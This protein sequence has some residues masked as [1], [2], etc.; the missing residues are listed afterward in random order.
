M[1]HIKLYET[2]NS[3]N[4][5]TRLS[6]E[7]IYLMCENF[8]AGDDEYPIIELRDVD[9]NKYTE[10]KDFIKNN[11]TLQI[12]IDTKYL[13]YYN[14][15]NPY[16]KAAYIIL[17]DIKVI[18]L[19][20]LHSTRETIIKYDDIKSNAFYMSKMY[21]SSLLHELIHAYDDYR[22]NGKYSDTTNSNQVINNSYLDY[23]NS[24]HEVGARFNQAFQKTDLK[25]WYDVDDKGMIYELLP[26]D[27]CLKAFRRN[28]INYRFLPETEKKRMSSMFAKYYIKYKTEFNGRDE[29]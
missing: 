3:H 29:E 15:H 22:S 10:I 13:K 11:L 16:D 8:K 20:E 23:S 24:K 6:N 18:C 27:V 2:Y 14:N 9:Y 4:E 1:K 19:V 5:L 26:F 28:F 7:I 21:L 17:P 25:K 12:F